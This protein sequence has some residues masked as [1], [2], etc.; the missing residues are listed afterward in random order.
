[1]K[2]KIRGIKSK[3]CYIIKKKKSKT[4]SYGMNIYNQLLGKDMIDAGDSDL[5]ILVRIF[6]TM[7]ILNTITIIAQLRQI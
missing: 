1:M 4:S 7:I 5:F 2:G 6:L 3:I